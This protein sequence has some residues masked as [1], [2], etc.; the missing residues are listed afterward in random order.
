VAREERLLPRLT[1]KRTPKELLNSLKRM[2][3]R[4][5]LRREFFQSLLAM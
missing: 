4:R 3:R 2:M 5:N 1:L